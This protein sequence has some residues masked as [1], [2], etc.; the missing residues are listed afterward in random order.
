M[1]VAMLP[2]MSAI[3]MPPPAAAATPAPGM[4]ARVPAM[5][6]PMPTDAM[7]LRAAY[8]TPDFVRRETDS[9]LWRYDAP[10]CAAFF[11]LYRDG[12]ALRLRYTETNPRGREAVADPAC[13]AKLDHRVPA[14]T[15]VNPSMQG[16]GRMRDV[17][18][19]R[20]ALGRF[21]AKGLW[22]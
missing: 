2:P 6:P 18:T 13:I 20:P 14:A 12:D 3:P 5:P 4:S 7:S 10:G 1:P 15:P 21:F 17:V 22:S 11:F 19:Y 9:E 16:S 8:G